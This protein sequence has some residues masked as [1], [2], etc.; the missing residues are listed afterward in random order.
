MEGENNLIL[1][2]IGGV[3]AGVMS[4]GVTQTLVQTQHDAKDVAQIF[5]KCFEPKMRPLETAD[6]IGLDNYPLL[7]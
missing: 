2:R 6:L 4:I 3:G 7:N 1:K 5:K